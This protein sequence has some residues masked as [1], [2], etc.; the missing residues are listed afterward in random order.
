MKWLFGLGRR[1]SNASPESA[2][3]ADVSLQTVVEAAREFEKHLPEGV[4][5]RVLVGEDNELK[6]ELLLSYLNARPNRKFYMSK[7]T[8]QVFEKEH[9]LIPQYLDKIQAAVDQYVKDLH[10]FPV[11]PS[12]PHKKISFHLLQQRGYIIDKPTIEFYLTDHEYLITHE[13]PDT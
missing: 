3:T 4:T 5:R 6:V 8:Y 10:Q 1:Q 13:K 12:H 2:P 11:I 9:K 7:E